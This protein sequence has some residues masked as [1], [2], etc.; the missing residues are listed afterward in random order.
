MVGLYTAGQENTQA[1]QNFKVEVS[2]LN[3]KMISIE[4]QTEEW[5]ENSEVSRSRL[6][7]IILK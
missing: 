7:I 3:S 4:K 6:T 5:K 2:A 1:F